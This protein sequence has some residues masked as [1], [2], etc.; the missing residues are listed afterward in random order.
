MA[1]ADRA[2]ALGPMDEEQPAGSPGVLPA[3]TEMGAPSRPRLTPDLIG[4]EA[5]EA[6]E[7]ARSTGVHLVVTVWRTAVGPWSKVLEQRPIAGTRVRRGTRVHVIV[8]ARPNASIPDVVGL[9]LVAATER[10]CWLGFVPIA[11]P[12]RS[13]CGLP[14]GHIVETR[15]AAGALVAQGSVVALTVAGPTRAETMESEPK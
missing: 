8:S 4:L 3:P 7:L 2:D 12:R 11:M 6:H 9:P 1:Y 15:P 14:A 5:P 13:V 10:L